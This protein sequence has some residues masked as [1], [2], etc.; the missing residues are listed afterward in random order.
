MHNRFLWMLLGAAALQAQP[1]LAPVINPRGV[2]NAMTLQ[3]APSSVSAG[4][5]I[6][7]NGLNLGPAAGATATGTTL[8]TELGGV[9]VL[10]NN[11]R[12]APLLSV[13]PAR[14]VAQ[15]PWEIPGGL[16]NVTVRRGGVTS[17]PARI[18]VVT[19]LPGVRT[20][21]NKGY[22]ELLGSISGRRITFQASGL[23]ITEPRLNTGEA[24]PGDP[25]VR[26][27]QPV[28]VHVG[29]ARVE[30]DVRASDK[31][32]GEFDI[33]IE[34]PDSA[35][36]GDLVTVDAQN[37][38]A[39]LATWRLASAPEVIF[40][41]MPQGAP[42]LR[43]L[44][45]SDLRGGFFLAS[46]ARRDDG[47]W[48][49]VL[50]DLR[51]KKATNVGE[52]LTAAN[53]N[54][55]SP[56]VPTPNGAPLAALVGPPQG[57]LP[58]GVSNKVVVYSPAKAEALSVE[59]PA[60]AIG[61]VG[62]DSSNFAAVLGGTPPQVAM[63]DTTSGEVRVQTGGPGGGGG[64]A[65][66]APGVAI[67]PA[68]LRIDLGGGIDQILAPP[69]NLG[70]GQIAVIVGDDENNPK[71]AKVAILNNQGEVT[72]S[73]DFPESWVPLVTPLPPQGPG[74]PGGGPGG[75]PGG[76]AGPAIR[77]RVSF[78][79]DAQTRT[80]YVLSRKADD[81]AHGLTAFGAN[82]VKPIP[83]PDKWFIAGCAPN[84]QVLSIETTRRIALLGSTT[85][86]R[87]FKQACP[88][89]A[90][91]VLDLAAQQFTA[92][93][94]PGQGQVN[95]S[96]R[97]DDMNDFL[98]AANTAGDTVF[99]LDGVTLTTYRF[100]LPQGVVGFNNLVTAPNIELAIATGRSR[101][102]GDA[103]FLI[104]DIERVE[105]RQLLLPDG[106]ATAQ[107][108]GLLPA[109]RKLV[110]RGTR[111]GNTGTQYLIYDLLTGEVFLPDNPPGVAFVGNVPAQQAPPGPGGQGG[112]QPQP[113]PVMQRVNQKANTIEAI[114]FG[115]DRTQNGALLIRVP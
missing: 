55:P 108:I 62:A 53:R 95:V 24:A 114:T 111:T 32:V 28:D 9:E 112:G 91:L 52:C 23:G 39:N 107:L 88:A 48:P 72:G 34:L 11:N 74:V 98:L 66:G 102:A 96:A 104:F 12:N 79:F 26:P 86:E 20:R 83:T 37:R 63:I 31:R 2:V 101:Q 106:F 65:G 109:T 97:A 92:V 16:A 99:A 78:Y 6:W 75:L 61:L 46:G 76:V 82:D 14:I 113:A 29:G 60:A 59:L 38:L 68:T 73:R 25:P 80:F 105:T 87:D 7:I 8:P 13:D 90:F 41:P 100:D 3:P 36:P 17:R 5:L 21:D 103:G 42:E 10:I 22:G 4:S 1:N 89:N 81:S 70:Q 54:A 15:V 58:Q 27:R 40:V 64:G 35:Q 45:G 19:P 49:S 115:A 47:C 110:A 69:V 50:F 33:T 57:E 56:A 77:N 51:A 93:E 85:A 71:K 94:L 84:A 67:N 44:S 43:A 18:N 30:A